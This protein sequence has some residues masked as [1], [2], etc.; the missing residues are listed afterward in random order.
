MSDRIIALFADTTLFGI[1]I[2]NLLLALGVALVTFLVARAA[3]GF[4]Y[5]GSGAGQNTTGH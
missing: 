3:I 4:C 5:G 2:V 1:S